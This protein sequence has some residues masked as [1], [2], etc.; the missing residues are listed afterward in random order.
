[1]FS[2]LNCFTSHCQVTSDY[3][4]LQ[5]QLKAKE[6]YIQDMENTH[7]EEKVELR[8]EL[9][10][11]RGEHQLEV[12]FLKKELEATRAN[13]NKIDNM[14]ETESG[15]KSLAHEQAQQNNYGEEISILREQ[16][17]QQIR[18]T[19]DAVEK[20]EQQEFD[21]HEELSSC[22]NMFELEKESF[23]NESR[24]N[25]EDLK[26]S[27]EEKL[28]L[29]EERYLEEINL[30]KSAQASVITDKEKS[31]GEAEIKRRTSIQY[32]ALKTEHE[33][34][35]AAL[36][37]E[38]ED[39][40]KMLKLQMKQRDEECTERET[41]MAE[42]MAKMHNELERQVVES[43]KAIAKELEEKNEAL[44]Q[45][46]L[47][48]SELEREHAKNKDD[49]Q[50]KQGDDHEGNDFRKN[51]DF[52]S[53]GTRSEK[54][55]EEISE[56]R[57]QLEK[58]QNLLEEE[59]RKFESALLNQERL[60]SEREEQLRKTIESNA[61]ELQTQFET[62]FE[63]VRLKHSHEISELNKPDEKLRVSEK[64]N[65]GSEL[66][67]DE[68]N[69]VGDGVIQ[70]ALKRQ[71]ELHAKE[72][73]QIKEQHEKEIEELQEL[74][75][76]L[77]DENTE[78]KTE[79]DLVVGDLA[80]ELE[81]EQLKSPN[82]KRRNS[83]V[84]REQ[85]EQLK[86]SHLRETRMLSDEL[87]ESKSKKDD[88]ENELE[89]LRTGQGHQ[90]DIA[91]KTNVEELEEKLRQLQNELLESQ[92]NTRQLEEMKTK[93]NSLEKE[94]EELSA[95]IS[96]QE[97]RQRESE[98]SANNL[99]SKLEAAEESTTN[100]KTQASLRE[101]EIKKLSETIVELKYIQSELEDENERLKDEIDDMKG[102]EI[103]AAV[104][105]TEA[106]LLAMEDTAIVKPRPKSEA[107]EYE[108]RFT[109]VVEEYEAKIEK[110]EAELQNVNQKLSL[111]E[112]Q[113]ESFN[114]EM[115]V[116]RSSLDDEA[117]NM[118]NLEEKLQTNEER[119]ADEVND[120]KAKLRASNSEKQT[121]LAD[122]EE[123]ME[124]RYTTMIESLKEELGSAIK[125]KESNE[126]EL[127]QVKKLLEDVRQ[128][129]EESEARY[130]TENS[131]LTHDNEVKTTNLVSLENQIEQL[132]QQVKQQEMTQTQCETKYKANE[133][134]Y[135]ETISS[136]TSAIA[137]LQ[138]ELQLLR[139][140]QKQAEAS[141]KA[142]EISRNGENDLK[143]RELATLRK[144]IEFFEEQKSQNEATIKAEQLQLK[145]LNDSK[146]KEIAGLNNQLQTLKEQDI[147]R[148]AVL[149]TEKMQLEE[150][151][152][153][154]GTEISSLKDELQVLHEQ[155]LRNEAKQ[156]AMQLEKDGQQDSKN[157]EIL[158][159]RSHLQILQNQQQIYES[160]YADEQD[161][162]REEN[163][164]KNEESATLREQV[165]Q[166]QDQL[167]TTEANKM[168][169]LL[170][171]K[172]DHL[173]KV[174]ELNDQ[175]SDKKREITN[176]R[177]ILED[178][179]SLK[180]EYEDKYS[181][182][183]EKRN[184][185]QAE[186]V[187][188]L[189]DKLQVKSSEVAKLKRSLEELQY[190]QKEIAFIQTTEQLKEHEIH[191]VKVRELEVELEKK[192]IE[193]SSLVSILESEQKSHDR[194]LKETERHLDQIDKV[195]EEKAHVRIQVEELKLVIQKL[196]G[197][198]ETERERC[199][200]LTLEHQTT[201]IDLEEL[202]EV[203]K[204]N[205]SL[206]EFEFEKGKLSNELEN[207]KNELTKTQEKYK[208][209]KDKFIYLKEK[210]Q[211]E[212]QKYEEKFLSPRIDSG[213]QTEI[214]QV[215]EYERMK[216]QSF[217]AESEKSRLEDNLKTREQ[218]MTKMKGE[219]NALKR[220]N[221]VL[222]K[223]N[224]VLY[225][226]TESLRKGLKSNINKDMETFEKENRELQLEN[227]ALRY[228]LKQKERA[229]FEHFDDE[230]SKTESEDM[231]G[232]SENESR[233][234]KEE[235]T[236]LLAKSKKLQVQ[237]E[238]LEKELQAIRYQSLFTGNGNHFGSTPRTSARE[239]VPGEN[240]SRQM[241]ETL[242]VSPVNSAL[243]TSVELQKI[244]EEQ[245]RMKQQI[246]LLSAE[247]ETPSVIRS[248]VEN[249]KDK[250]IINDVNGYIGTKS[251][252]VSK[253]IKSTL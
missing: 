133:K 224:Q 220:A 129:Q 218:E 241:V 90:E 2:L 37:E 24:N 28:Q 200:Q 207:S 39:D 211:E 60:F 229:D 61:M 130:V 22:K 172:Q 249:L 134:E 74:I 244:V 41:R 199:H 239:V 53:V 135:S 232:R 92:Q 70:V 253:L 13:E 141:Y 170:K 56:L 30:L 125:D 46:Q 175:L 7:A 243:N 191:T 102:N 247:R 206:N 234:M 10:I 36:K 105:A 177:D 85:I 145:Q 210:L 208:K 38:Y 223:Q 1:M 112:K 29:Q 143:E 147:Q 245:A 79:Y 184:R 186:K 34:Y 51:N 124:L 185:E 100:Q 155:Q 190:Q 119:Y 150:E 99:K 161:K 137:K 163:S 117:I 21:F 204:L 222:I 120:L 174:E 68:A 25:I 195:G 121:S 246:E 237:V 126:K 106:D 138:E 107:L 132:L 42:D 118:Q 217:D 75:E 19:S 151:N 94:R 228:S 113:M 8:L 189:E 31:D 205:R 193:I 127:F 93:I 160:K 231:H 197:D 81:N 248:D 144:Q 142:D 178:V 27:Y 84:L 148:I 73:E 5:E 110:L 194:I 57:M 219:V 176:L 152:K 32:A 157:Q 154:K 95:L 173:N 179:K 89:I 109:G 123:Q 86:N 213:L 116:L 12:D 54:Y 20:L 226:E 122:I 212:Q 169:E 67:A 71:A 128:T 114:S 4:N 166:L 171:A 76:N 165:R 111:K 43:K 9:E 162:L 236:F 80:N 77:Q 17:Q 101:Q 181:T 16:L 202:E 139:A 238:E 250:D 48:F 11:A 131:R 227:E 44:L 63:Q 156:M 115:D 26:R 146:N 209:L 18:N 87:E 214:L 136:K 40:L 233:R 58:D 252:Q 104:A 52:E 78:L 153:V 183:Q 33:T 3:E 149:N 59:R 72:V 203:Q 140:Q 82:Y 83:A 108:Q 159:L 96:Q 242:P 35:V 168:S 47:E 240:A 216:L 65:K 45:L 91:S 14:S 164:Q 64:S 49:V 225:L 230:L 98:I 221:A 69:Q 50:G 23:I 97:E 235:N 201:K 55:E 180:S 66:L 196:R 88:L 251:H 62:K 6:R 103:E 182:E 215:E 158:E 187:R 192:S 188:S 15:E 198:L 167:A